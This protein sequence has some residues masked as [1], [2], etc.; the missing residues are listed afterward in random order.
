MPKNK[1]KIKNT[2]WRNDFVCTL[3]YKGK[4]R[5]CY[6]LD[7]K[8]IKMRFPDA[9][10]RAFKVSTQLFDHD[11][12]EISS[13]KYWMGSSLTMCG[14]R[15]T[16]D[17]HNRKDLVKDAARLLGQIGGQNGIGKKKVRGDSNYY[18]MLQLKGALVKKNNS[19]KKA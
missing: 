8:H 19:P 5:K 14:N 16:F 7:M 13:N 6:G 2:P 10:R 11:M 12:K 18:R 4:T 9:C 17:I 3:V 1:K 15:V